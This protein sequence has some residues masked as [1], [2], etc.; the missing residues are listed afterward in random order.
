MG[1]KNDF[2]NTLLAGA[3]A[4][5]ASSADKRLKALEAK[6]KERE[7]KQAY[8]EK[9]YEKISQLHQSLK[10]IVELEPLEDR[11]AKL[12]SLLDKLK[13]VDMSVVK[14]ILYKDRYNE[15]KEKATLELK[16][17][18]GELTH[19][20]IKNYEQELF[21]IA[22]NITEPIAR[23]Q[24]QKIVEKKYSFINLEYILYPEDKKR[25]NNAKTQLETEYQKVKKELGEKRWESIVNIE[26]QLPVLRDLLSKNEK[27]Y[28]KQYTE[29]ITKLKS[30]AAL[31]RQAHIQ[32][33]EYQD[34]NIEVS[35]SEADSIATK[36]D[37]RVAMIKC[38]ISFTKCGGEITPKQIKSILA[39]CK[40]MFLTKQDFENII[41]EAD[42]FNFSTNLSME[43]KI[44]FLLNL[45][46]LKMNLSDVEQKFFSNICKTLDISEDKISCSIF[47]RW[48]SQDQE[49]RTGIGCGLLFLVILFVI[50]GYL[51]TCSSTK[52][53]KIEGERFQNIPKTSNNSAVVASDKTSKKKDDRNNI[54]T[55]LQNAEMP[56]FSDK[57]GIWVNCYQTESSGLVIMG[58]TN[59]PAESTLFCSLTYGVPNVYSQT[60]ETQV[61]RDGF[62]E[63][64]VFKEN[65]GFYNGEYI[66]T[67]YSLISSQ[68]KE[69][70]K[71]ILG[72]D[73]AT[74]LK[75]QCVVDKM[76]LGKHIKFSFKIQ[77]SGGAV[78]KS[79]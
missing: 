40:K 36:Y 5:K 47:A 3:A 22:S 7:R 64:P 13:K 43:D 23:Y 45:K 12:I 46:K 32:V 1:K 17:A 58:K 28:R 48:K 60:F 20:Q 41:N 2:L 15:I 9:Q 35:I 72:G 79:R 33:P 30:V 16:R 26:T 21:D 66:A 76:E 19:Q 57:V 69:S 51:T 42:I 39:F 18:Q 78:P 73:L 50:G 24:K 8:L 6:E 77:L 74:N 44:F 4:N 63:T 27:I 10:I 31:I 14:D 25:Y 61:Q 34:D 65:G 38:M 53:N 52:S 68:E 59:L 29:F 55:G 62:F 49:T 70:V 11:I 37:D 56:N 54:I 67:V 75:G 71:K